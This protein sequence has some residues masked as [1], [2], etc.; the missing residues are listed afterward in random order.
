[1]LEN[2]GKWREALISQRLLIGV[3]VWH[4]T[5]T[6]R[7]LINGSGLREVSEWADPSQFINKGASA[8]SIKQSS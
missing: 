1:M 2:V 4:N 3:F 8:N 5:T 6:L 7:L